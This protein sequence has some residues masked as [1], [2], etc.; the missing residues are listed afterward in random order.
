MRSLCT[1]MK[2]SPGS[3]QLGKAHTRQRRL[4]AVKSFKNNFFK[5]ELELNELLLVKIN[6]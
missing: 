5:K 2:S 6:Y 4:S 3:Q 1:T